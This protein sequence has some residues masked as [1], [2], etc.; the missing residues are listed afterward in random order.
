M[1]AS[2]IGDGRV[3]IIEGANKDSP[4]SMPTTTTLTFTSDHL[5]RN[6]VR[7]D[8]KNPSIP[9]APG[10][11][12]KADLL[13][14]LLDIKAARM[15]SATPIE[16]SSQASE[17]SGDKTYELSSSETHLSPGM[18]NVDLARDVQ[19]SCPLP[20]VTIENGRARI[21]LS[22]IPALKTSDKSTKSVETNS[23]KSTKA[24]NSS[25]S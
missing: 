22:S 3:D 4:N 1:L 20:A 16:A 14:E 18:R 23:S 12:H 13:H 19:K 25:E 11:V 10:D 2:K 21:G 15:P 7:A 9:M 6:V 24:S 17:S 5:V 8:F